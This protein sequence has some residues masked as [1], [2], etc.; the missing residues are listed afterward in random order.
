VA[1]LINAEEKNGVKLWPVPS[2]FACIAVFFFV[3]FS[4]RMRL[5]KIMAWSMYS[6]F[7]GCSPRAAAQCRPSLGIRS[8]LSDK[9]VILHRYYKVRTMERRIPPSTFHLPMP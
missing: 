9:V 7:A 2:Y 4:T 5:R 8:D 6:P 3:L 1:S